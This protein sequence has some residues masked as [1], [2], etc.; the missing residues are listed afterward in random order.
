MDLR[1]IANDMALVA[2]QNPH[3]QEKHFIVPECCARNI[4]YGDQIVETV[5]SFDIC[6]VTPTITKAAWHLSV[7]PKRDLTEEEWQE[8]LW[9]FFGVGPVQEISDEV[10]ASFP[11]CPIPKL[12]R[13]FIK[14][15]Q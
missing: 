2:Q 11:G 6:R 15:V 8:W 4:A 14:L 12:Q 5:F 1:T 9:A 13:Q 3:D 7:T 10:R